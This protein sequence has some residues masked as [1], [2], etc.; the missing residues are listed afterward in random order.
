MNKVVKDAWYDR[1]ID[2][3]SVNSYL[4]WM[5][6]DN[7]KEDIESLYATVADGLNRQLELTDNE[8][9]NPYTIDIDGQLLFT[10]DT[11]KQLVIDVNDKQDIPSDLAAHQNNIIILEKTLKIKFIMFG[12]FNHN[13]PVT[14]GDMVLYKGKPHRLLSI[15]PTADGKEVYDLYNGYTEIKNVSPKKIK[16]NPN[17]FLQNFRIFCSNDTHTSDTEFTDYMYIVITKHKKEGTA[18]DVDKY[19]LVKDI[20]IPFIFTE[21]KIPIYI[22]Y[23]IF[24]SC[25]GLDKEELNK[26]GYGNPNLRD[27]ILYFETSRRERIDQ[28][29]IRDDIINIKDKIARY[30]KKY[31]Q[32]KAIKEKSLE[33]QAEQLLYKEDIKDLKQR[34][35][36]LEEFLREEGNIS[37]GA[38]T[39][40]PSEQ[41]PSYV[42]QYNPLGYPLNPN[43]PP[44]NVIYMPRQGYPYQNSYY[45]NQY[46]VPY[47]V[48][49]N[50]AKDQKSKL[51]F[52]ITIELELFPGKSANMLQKSVVRCQSTFERIREA[53]ADIF[54]FEYRPAPM[55]EAYAYNLQKPEDKK[56]KTEKKR[57]TEKNKTRK[58]KT[59]K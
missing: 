10:A 58:L 48:S 26:M 13:L 44:G 49:Q 19:Q 7:D 59:R 40:R 3:I 47:N 37:G 22:K 23:F 12:M 53:W 42:P 57:S 43:I 29:N 1:I 34:R 56:N 5:V 36:M 20:N 25:P 39:L 27:D 51:S 11:I 50:K 9:T 4:D 15:K 6:F 46:R 32:L 52:Y 18:D 16:V 41:Y 35:S 38:A 21:D 30:E 24:N 14:V 28:E 54:G 33:Q 31:N 45:S 17:N 8:T 2:D 55:N